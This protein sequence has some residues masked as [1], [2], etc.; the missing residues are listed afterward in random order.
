MTDNK[1]ERDDKQKD[2]F[3]DHLLS[4]EDRQRF[5]QESGSRRELSADMEL[6]TKIDAS[7]RRT[8]HFDRPDREQISQLARGTELGKP[9]RQDRTRRQLAALVA[10]A[11][12]LLIMIGAGV[13]QYI[14]NRQMEP[15]FQPQPLARIYEETVERGF[16]PYY[17]CDDPERFAEV[18]ERRH[19]TRLGLAEMPAGS[20][21]VGISFLGGFSRNTTAMLCEVDRRN[22]IVFVDNAE[23]NRPD[24]ALPDGD[25]G[26]NIFGV[27]K[28]QL[29]FYEVTP[30]PSSG[31]IDHF[32]ILD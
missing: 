7:L 17:L 25:S 23:N 12:I 9:P 2:A 11:A 32:L 4:D 20:F 30:L 1:P 10:L 31:V 26:L 13:W 8:F 24:L 18:F 3:F 6:Q 5:L 27:R 16:K 15:A 21:M 28:D 19:G 29:I 22:V 14:N